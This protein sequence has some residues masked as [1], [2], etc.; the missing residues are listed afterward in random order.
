[1]KNLICLILVGLFG[2][3]NAQTI[4]NTLGTTDNTSSFDV[5]AMDATPLFRVQ[6]DG[7]AGFLNAIP[8]QFPVHA[9]SDH[10][11]NWRDPTAYFNN[12]V[13]EADGVGVHGN[14][15]NNDFW[16]VG[17]S[18][19]GGW[20]GVYGWVNPTGDHFYNGVLGEVSGGTGIN[21][22]VRGWGFQGTDAYG[23]YGVGQS[24]TENSY[25]VHG[26][27]TSGG[28]F[29]FGV[30]GVGHGSPM[31]YG[32]YGWASDVAD[33]AAGYNCAGYFGATTAAPIN[34]GIY[35]EASG[36][37]TN[38][39]GW[40]AGDVNCTGTLSKA[41]GAF[42]IDHPLDPENKYLSH[43]FVESPDMMNI[44]NGNAKLN[45]AGEAEI[46]LPDWFHSLNSDFRYQLTAIG[47]PGPNLYV[48]QEVSGNTFRVAGGEPGMKVSWQITGIRQD[49][50]ANANRI[51]VEEYKT[52]NDIGKY[53]HPEAF[54]MPRSQGINNNIIAQGKEINA[55]QKDMMIEDDKRKKARH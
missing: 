24:G 8:P 52:I 34:Y 37:V 32:V 29:S 54:G 5:Q 9:S 35:A 39:A 25:G 2:F 48:A 38:W 14:S 28:S 49:A 26:Y 13:T 10:Y 42:K 30:Y 18:G 53:L 33:P 43:S 46:E 44:Y 51:K 17:T 22:G 36:A 55:Q 50:Y 6:G 47:A 27:G 40:F 3:I 20:T 23:V 41:A 4:I 21:R 12:T 1:M 11:V 45:Y 15:A 19:H 31:N 7:W 16:G